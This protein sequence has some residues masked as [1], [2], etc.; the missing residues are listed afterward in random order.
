MPFSYSNLNILC[1][2]LCG[3]EKIATEFVCH[4]RQEGLL[5]PTAQRSA[6]ETFCAKRETRILSVGGRCLLARILR[7]NAKMLIPFD[8]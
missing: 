2:A 4:I 5:T 8:R 1:T 7:E 3:L 6:C